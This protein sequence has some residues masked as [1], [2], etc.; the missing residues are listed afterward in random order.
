MLHIMAFSDNPSKYAT[1]IWEDIWFVNAPLPTQFWG[2][3]ILV[4]EKNKTIADIWDGQTLKCIF[5]RISQ[6]R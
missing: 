6:M 5:K 3:Y 2:L 4:N 1:F